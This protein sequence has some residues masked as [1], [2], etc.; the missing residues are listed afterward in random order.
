MI[1]G[2]RSHRG[3]LQRSARATVAN[4]A[5]YATAFEGAAG[6]DIRMEGFVG[7]G[8]GQPG[9]RYGTPVITPAPGPTS[10]KVPL[11]LLG[12]VLLLASG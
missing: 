1:G 9:S 12:V 4:V 6:R 8:A 5:E 3:N 10:F 7:A 11:I 2:S